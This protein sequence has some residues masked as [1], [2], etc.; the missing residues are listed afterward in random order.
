MRVGSMSSVVE[1]MR[2]VRTSTAS[3]F[4]DNPLV[5]R[6]RSKLRPSPRSSLSLADP[7]TEY[8][9][10]RPN[11]QNAIDIF[12]G[13][14][15]SKLPG[16][17]A[18]LRAGSSDLFDDAR[19]TW[20]DEVVGGVK[21]KAVLELG[22][23]EGGHTYM[24]E[25]LGAASILGIEANKR[26][27]LR[28]LITKELLRTE[29]ARFECGDF[30]EY[31]RLPGPSFDIVLASGVLYHMHNPAELISLIAGRCSGHVLLWTHYFDAQ[32]IGGNPHLR[33][34]FDGGRS[35]TFGGFEHTLYRQHYGAALDWSGFCGGNEPESEWMSR[36]DLVRALEHFGFRDLRIAFDS[37]S[38]PN[39]PA[40][41]I[42]AG[43]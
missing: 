36:D 10:T 18:A 12:A 29:R 43:R 40:L 33:H 31:L 24:L 35:A 39:G 34:K 37:S 32:T 2:T 25:R 13:E 14:W 26:A 30:L 28:C 38:H 11:P 41:A 17:F 21:G 1:A 27:F 9:R 16:E 23:L 3:R 19:I 42:V 6:L 4:A 15:S 7:L 22:P 5:R 8:V 20:L